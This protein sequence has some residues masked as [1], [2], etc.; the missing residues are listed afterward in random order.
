MCATEPNLE[1]CGFVCQL[2]NFRLMLSDLHTPAGVLHALKAGAS[3]VVITC[4]QCHVIRLYARND[5]LF[6]SP[7][8]TQVPFVKGK[9]TSA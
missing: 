6:S 2:C 9:S 1:A 7:D 8:G 4:P 3:Y 5:L